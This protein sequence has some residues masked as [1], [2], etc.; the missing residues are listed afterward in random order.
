[1]KTSTKWIIGGGAVVVI[2][3]AA[4]LTINMWMPK[5]KK[6]KKDLLEREISH[7]TKKETANAVR[8]V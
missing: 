6:D 3:V 4:Y 1:M 8:A 2:G 7:R 5:S